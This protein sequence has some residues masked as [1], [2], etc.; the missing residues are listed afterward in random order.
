MGATQI[1]ALVMTVLEHL[2][3]ALDHSIRDCQ[4]C[5]GIRRRNADGGT[6]MWSELLKKERKEVILGYRGQESFEL[7]R[8]LP[9]QA[10]SPLFLSSLIA[11]LG[12]SISTPKTPF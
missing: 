8:I 12:A 10:G 5:W 3:F 11:R 4:Y 9:R 1:G 2:L 6:N 7:Q